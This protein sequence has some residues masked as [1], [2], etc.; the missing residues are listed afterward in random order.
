MHSFSVSFL[1][2][3]IKSGVLF[4]LPKRFYRG[5]NVRKFFV[6]EVDTFRLSWGFFLIRG[7]KFYMNIFVSQYFNKDLQN[8]LGAQVTTNPLFSRD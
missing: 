8:V 7:F 6:G 3:T 4:I 5:F 1:K 2:S